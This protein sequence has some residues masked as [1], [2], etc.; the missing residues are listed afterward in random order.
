MGY[1]IQLM[2]LLEMMNEQLLDA[3]RRVTKIKSIH[4]KLWENLSIETM[5]SYFFRRYQVPLYNKIT[6]ILN[7]AE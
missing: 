5:G 7:G 4:M 6:K 2:E 1:I 3:F